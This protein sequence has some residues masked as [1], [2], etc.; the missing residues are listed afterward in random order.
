MKLIS[1][2]KCS[3]F[4]PITR[5]QKSSPD[6]QVL[7]WQRNNQTNPSCW[8]QS[9]QLAPIPSSHMAEQ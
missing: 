4:V 1:E 2:G 9:L 6:Q 3:F 5:T 8:Q 7:S